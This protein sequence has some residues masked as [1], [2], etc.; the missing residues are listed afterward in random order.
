VFSCEGRRLIFPELSLSKNKNIPAE[1]SFEVFEEA[2]VWSRD[3]QAQ[4][5]ERCPTELGQRGADGNELSGSI[6][7]WEILE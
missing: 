1:C 6:K 2:M 3:A 4:A 5:Q 7:C